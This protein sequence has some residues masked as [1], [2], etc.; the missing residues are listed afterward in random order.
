MAFVNPGFMIP[1]TFN[2]NGSV[3][4]LTDVVLG[5]IPMDCEIFFIDWVVHDADNTFDTT[6]LTLE[7]DVSTDGTTYGDDTAI[8]AIQT[9]AATGTQLAGR[10]DVDDLSEGTI[11]LTKAQE[12]YG[13][14][15]LLTVDNVSTGADL[16]VTFIFWVVPTDLT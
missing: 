6:L 14:R 4:N 11:S 12:P 2:Y 7:Y 13:A 8:D 15:I 5:Y 3:D 9:G 16:G 10:V 1:V